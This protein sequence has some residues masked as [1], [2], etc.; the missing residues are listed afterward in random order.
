MLAEASADFPHPQLNYLHA[1]TAN[2]QLPSGKFDVAIST[3]SIIPETRSAVQ[4]MYSEIYRILR[5]GGRF[6]AYLPS[7]TCSEGIAECYPEHQQYLDPLQFRV[8]DTTGWQCFHTADTIQAELKASGFVHFALEK[9]GIDNGLEREHLHALYG[10]KAGMFWEFLLTARRPCGQAKRIDSFRTDY[11]IEIYKSEQL[12]NKSVLSRAIADFYRFIF[13]NQN[14]HYL[15]FPSTL[16]LIAP[17]E[18]FREQD[19]RG[20]Y[21]DTAIMDGLKN[22]PMHPLTLE[23]AIFWHHPQTTQE[24]LQKKFEK[25]VILALLKDSL[26]S[27]VGV[28]FGY[29][30]SAEEIFEMEGWRNPLHYAG[31]E[32]SE[33][34]RNV[35]ECLRIIAEFLDLKALEPSD[36]FLCYNCVALDPVLH[37]SKYAL[38]LII[39]FLESIPAEKRN[40][41][42]L[43]EVWFRSKAHHIFNARGM[44]VVPGLLNS[45]HEP[46]LTGSVLAVSYVPDLLAGFGLCDGREMLT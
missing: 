7:Y 40:T 43:S 18:M 37:G 32:R 13:S 12:R 23:S 14:C 2:L 20:E 35:N 9:I 11:Y 17:E 34:C 21:I 15:V 45:A 6:V 24:E 19:C 30:A 38:L 41:Y 29:F 22:L 39:K 44:K 26:G 33:H 42:A 28:T 46:S 1:N 4:A 25:E 16:D 36:E 10:E 5:S 31:I 8:F 27:I 3:N